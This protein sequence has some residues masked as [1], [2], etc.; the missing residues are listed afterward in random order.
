[1]YHFGTYIV[2]IIGAYIGA[3]I[4]HIVVTNDTQK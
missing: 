1:M 3:Y 2:R 4:G